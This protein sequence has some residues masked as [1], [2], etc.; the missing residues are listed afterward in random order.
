M[1][2]V[3]MLLLI[4]VT[5]SGPALYVPVVALPPVKLRVGVA[6]SMERVTVVLIAL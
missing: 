3:S 6:R 1:A 2:Y 5:R 4:A